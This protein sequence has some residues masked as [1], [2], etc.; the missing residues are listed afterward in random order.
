MELAHGEVDQKPGQWHRLQLHFEGDS[1]TALIDG[2]QVA[3]I[4][5]ST[6]GHGMFSLGSNWT[7]VQFDNLKVEPVELRMNRGR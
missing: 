4:S 1:I 3:E 6:H 2:Q 5:D 7:P